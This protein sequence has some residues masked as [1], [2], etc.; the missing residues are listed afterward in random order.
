MLG[1][2]AEALGDPE[3]KADYGIKYAC[4]A[5]AMYK[6]I[7][8]RTF[9]VALG[10]GGS[11][12]FL[13]TGGLTH[14]EIESAIQGI[15]SDLGSRPYGVNLLS[16]GNP[17]FEERLVDLF[18][19]YGV[20][21]VE[22][23]SFVRITPALVRF[24]LRGVKQGSGGAIEVP[25]RI[26]AKVAQPEVARAFMQPA[27]PAIIEELLRSGRITTGEAELGR[28]IP[29]AQDICVEADSGG[30]TERG[31]AYALM[32]V[33]L[34]LRDAMMAQYQYRSRIRVGAAG[35]IGS[36]HAAAA[37][38]IMGADFIMT[39]SINQ[40]TREA[41]TSESAKDILETLDAGDTAYAPA[42]GLFE[43]GGQMQ[44]AKRGL[45]F[46]V[47]ANELYELYQRN[48]SLEELDPKT[49][50]RI[51]EAYFMRSFDEVWRETRDY[52][53]RAHPHRLCAID[54]D[55]RQKMAVVFKWYF[56]Q[57]A[58]WAIEGNDAQRVNYQIHCGP[59]LGTFNQLVKGT[60]LQSWRNRRVADV[61]QHLMRGT[62]SLL[63]N[64][65]S[66]YQ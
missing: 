44:V 63:C 56:V 30:H 40:C 28:L 13:G 29:V 47:R 25:H 17:A 45:F 8:S 27:P 62:A 43:G 48:G 46:P 32:P 38:F 58:R 20:R 65:V 49:S 36:P 50:A 31:V 16:N 64:R 18:L 33:I 37:A 3:F 53:S 54:A 4:L 1:I 60:E 51:Q 2:T 23:A 55:P 9:V 10:K 22:A 39:G 19:G 24:R 61:T 21:H 34:A 52:Y 35:G 59:A 7:S 41:G 12:G 57:S 42:G 66:S 5:G 11:M 26:L 6:G 14:P 15:Q